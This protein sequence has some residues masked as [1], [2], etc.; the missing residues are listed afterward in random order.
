MRWTVERDLKEGC[1]LEALNLMSSHPRSDF[2]THWDP[3]PRVG[4]GEK[5]PPVIDVVIVILDG[6]YADWVVALIP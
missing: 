5:N 3:P 4:Y 6:K 1:I 2:P